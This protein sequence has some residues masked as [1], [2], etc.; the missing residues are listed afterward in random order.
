MTERIDH[1]EV[2]LNNLDAAWKSPEQAQFLAEAQ[3]HATLA[4]V[5]ERRTANLIAYLELMTEHFLNRDTFETS[6]KSVA[7]YAN[8][9]KQ[10]FDR[11]G[12]EAA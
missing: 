12:I 2:A 7:V 5:E 11:L 10:V 6:D 3:A 4:L 9:S 1:A 8:V